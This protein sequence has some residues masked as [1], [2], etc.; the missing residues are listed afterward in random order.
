MGRAAA[1]ASRIVT[2]LGAI[3]RAV[4]CGGRGTVATAVKV[5]WLWDGG[6]PAS[7]AYIDAPSLPASGGS[8]GGGTRAPA[9]T[10]TRRSTIAMMPT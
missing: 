2:S 8:S 1:A 5:Q 4:R 7:G 10:L 9:R 3:I 6:L